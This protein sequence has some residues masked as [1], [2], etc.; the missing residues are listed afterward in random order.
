MFWFPSFSF[1]I[2]SGL[3]R[4]TPELLLKVKP[5]PGEVKSLAVGTFRVDYETPTYST[6]EQDIF[7]ILIKI[8]GQGNFPLFLLS[9]DWNL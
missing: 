8:T 5:I 4:N 6:I 3:V 9:R 2:G 7:T 1:N